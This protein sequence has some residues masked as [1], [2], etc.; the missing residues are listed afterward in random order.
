MYLKLKLCCKVTKKQAKDKE[1]AWIF[2]FVFNQA[3]LQRF[4]RRVKFLD[5]M[6]DFCNFRVFS[7]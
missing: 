6:G 3:E 5:E 1:N 7:A 4:W 2:Y